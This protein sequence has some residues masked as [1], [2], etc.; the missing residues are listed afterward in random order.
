M[1]FSLKSAA[2]VA[3]YAAAALMPAA[4]LAGPFTAGNLLVERLGDGSTAL[5]G[6][7]AQVNVLEVTTSGSIA[8]TLSSEFTGGNLQSD[9]G[10]ATSNGYLGTGGGQYLAVSGHNAAVGTPSVAS[11]NNKV[12]QIIDATTGNVVSRVTFPT[13]GPSG[14]PPSPYSGNNFRSII[15]TGSNTFY[16]A[17]NSSGSPVTAGL[18]YYDGSAFTQLSTTA[19]TNLRN[20]EIYNNQLYFSTGSGTTGIYTM[21]TGLPTTG[22]QTP[23][24]VPGMTATTPYGFVMF[25]TN[26]DSVLDLAYVADDGAVTGGGL[27]KFTF[28]GTTWSNAWS[29]LN[30]PNGSLSATTAAGFLGIRGLAGSFSGGV[31]TLFATT[32]EPSNNRLISITDNLVS[33]PTTFTAL[34]SAGTNYVFRGVDV[35][36]VPE[37]S[38]VGLA[39]AGGLGLAGLAARRRLRKA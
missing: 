6:A 27:K 14:T 33:T 22:S 38:T 16:T 12:A 36:V 1:K 31:A 29:L 9:S 21:G 5:T 7:A 20:V 24:P 32:T 23:T 30:N 35:A 25:D 34:Q 26:A 11:Q 18:W 28:N 8:Q 13:G 37:P 39:I 2:I 4:A 15:P 17:G 10:S 3:A 19:P